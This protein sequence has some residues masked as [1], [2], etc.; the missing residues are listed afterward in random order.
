MKRDTEYTCLLVV[1]YIPVD[2]ARCTGGRPLPGITVLLRV[3]PASSGN[4]CTTPSITGFHSRLKRNK[5]SRR[6][7]T[8][9]ASFRANKL[10]NIC[11][12]EALRQVMPK[13]VLLSF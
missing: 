2:Y 1:R 6:R 10:T 4:Y 13:N 12:N 8:A 7:E 5:A 3:L 11:Y 9:E